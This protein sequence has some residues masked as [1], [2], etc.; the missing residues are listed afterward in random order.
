MCVGGPLVFDVGTGF[1][2]KSSAFKVHIL[3]F[4]TNLALPALMD[5]NRVIPHHWQTFEEEI[6]SFIRY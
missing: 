2:C 5:L 1:A 4:I 3:K 6:P